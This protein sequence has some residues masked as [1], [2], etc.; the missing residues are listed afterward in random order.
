MNRPKLIRNI[1]VRSF[2]KRSGKYFMNKYFMKKIDK[3]FPFLYFPL[4]SE[5]ERALSITAPYYT[6]QLEVITSVARSI[7]VGYKLYVKDHPT[8]ILK[9]GR[10]ISFYKNIM[11]LPNVEM[12]H[13]DIKK[14]EILNNCSLVISITGTAGLEAVFFGKPS[15][16]F[17][18][19]LYSDLPSVTVLKSINELPSAI[20]ES[21]DTKVDPQDLS[22]FVNFIDSNSF[23]NNRTILYPDFR[24]R[25]QYK[26]IGDSDMKSFI[27]DH[28]NTY[29]SLAKEHIK[30]IKILS[31]KR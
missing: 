8:M 12:I 19:N 31:K 21:L 5:P 6:N 11:K 17:T 14:E 3:E 7:P 22:K 23:Q 26:E 1:I 10:S 29:Q 20:L 4:H 25:F 16:I 30:K 9:G 24:S 15:I 28:K 27:D 2:R 13:T 18:S